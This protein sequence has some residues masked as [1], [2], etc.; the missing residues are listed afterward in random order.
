MPKNGGNVLNFLKTGLFE[1]GDL[2]H[3]LDAGQGQHKQLYGSF[4]ALQPRSRYSSAMP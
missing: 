2:C 4:N 3:P 1:R